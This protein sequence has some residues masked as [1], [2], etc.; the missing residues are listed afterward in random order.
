MVLE[1]LLSAESAQRNPWAIT[2]LAFVF[3]S[4][5]I[6]ATLVLNLERADFILVLFVALPSIPFLLRLFDC[7]AEEAE[8]KRVL[9]SRTLARYFPAIIVMLSYFLG[10]IIGFTVWYAVLPQ[11]VGTQLFS[12][13]EKELQN[14]QANF[15]AYATKFLDEEPTVFETIFL[16]NLQVLLLVLAFSV[17]YGAGA[18][19]ILV[20]NASVISVFLVNFAGAFVLH[21][22]GAF[23]K[24]LGYGLLGVLPHG[25]F[26]LLAY[27]T[28]ALAGGILSSAIIRGAYK[29]PEFSQIIYDTAKLTG[30]AIIFLALGA[31]IEG[32][33]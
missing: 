15:Q 24:G 22:P 4:L 17:L 21:E 32:G 27:T 31:F 28:G 20:W 1:S 2:V 13:Q 30:W 18:V 29:R 8:H 12:L 33:V 14:I 23:A 10:L 7:E 16:H 26:E 11:N 3:V 25:L 6:L 9:G 19:F 5:G